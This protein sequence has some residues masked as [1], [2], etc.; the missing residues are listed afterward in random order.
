MGKTIQAE[1]RQRAWPQEGWTRIPFWVYTDPELFE[2]EMETFFYG[3]S[4]NYVA[5]DCEVPEPGAYKRSWIGTRQVIVVRQKDGGV[6]V[7]ENRCAHR[8]SRVCWQNKG[9]VEL[10]ATCEAVAA[11]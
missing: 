4:W 10:K 9:K 3:R 1:T 6:A 11:K 5:L 2:R 8:G 7:L